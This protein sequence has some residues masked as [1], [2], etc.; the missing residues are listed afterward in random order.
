MF[1]VC[2]G[3]V[4]TQ[5]YVVQELSFFRVYFIIF[6]LITNLRPQQSPSFV[7]FFPLQDTPKSS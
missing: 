4:K 6:L 7:F 5:P 1:C 3:V 2:I